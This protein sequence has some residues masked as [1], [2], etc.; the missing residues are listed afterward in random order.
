M[1]KKIAFVFIF[2]LSILLA[3]GQSITDLKKS[4]TKAQ[5]DINKSN[6]LLKINKSKTT[7][8][9]DNIILTNRNIENREVIISLVHGQ[10]R[11]IENT[12][13]ENNFK[14]KSLN[15]ELE[16]ERILYA[17]IMRSSYKQYIS[18]SN[19]KFL[20]SFA[21]IQDFHLRIYYLNKYSQM[22]K[23]LSN[24]IK[25]NTQSVFSANEIL[26]QKRKE[27]EQANNKVSSEIKMLESEKASYNK[28]H[29]NLMKEGKTLRKKVDNSI[30]L[31][32]KLE[33]Q[34]TKIIAEEH[35][36]RLKKKISK[37]DTQ[38]SSDFAKNKGKLPSPVKGGVITEK[39]G[40][41]KH[42]LYPSI[43]VDNK[44]VNFAVPINST[45][46]SVFNGV[47]TRVFFLQGLNNSVMVRH[48]DFI[49][50]YSGLTLVNVKNGDIVTT[51]EVLGKTMD[52]SSPSIHFEI[53]KGKTALNPEQW[54]K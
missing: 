49:T 34:I 18:S 29:G 12:V 48:G 39:Y 25:R 26:S 17:K 51:G 30:R 43:L 36:A 40:V 37:K 1:I 28:M 13:G 47:V 6:K 8:A 15:S 20:L 45:V 3:E 42:P 16:K 50:V 2:S 54:L 7:S 46:T 23:D 44:G 33:K 35:K 11:I 53:H 52:I 32:L 5:N 41:H 4:I 27:L 38:L 10:I 24:S 22:K 9:I 31:K 19:L 21:S 14:V